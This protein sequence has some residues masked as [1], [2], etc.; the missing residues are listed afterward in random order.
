MYT[1]INLFDVNE[2][3]CNIL[4]LRQLN[5]LSTLYTATTAIDSAEAKEESVCNETINW[6]AFS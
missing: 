2:K 5:P 1:I 4:P 3:I 6:L